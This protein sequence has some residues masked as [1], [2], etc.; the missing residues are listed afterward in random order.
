[1]IRSW[2]EILLEY[3]IIS[4]HQD[5]ISEKTTDDK[6]PAYPTSVIEPGMNDQKLRNVDI[7]Y[8]QREMNSW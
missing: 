3:V 5:I 1:M 8:R 4:T 7:S 2:T 6:I